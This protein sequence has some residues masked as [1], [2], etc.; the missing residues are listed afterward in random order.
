LLLD[1]DAPID[2]ASTSDT[3]EATSGAYWHHSME[4]EAEHGLVE[5]PEP[6]T[7]DDESTR[8]DDG[9][10]AVDNEPTQ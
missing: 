7:W 1:G 5:D 4:N 9:A 2:D 3:T 6:G 8:D 10:G